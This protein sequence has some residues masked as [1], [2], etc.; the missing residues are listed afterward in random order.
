MHVLSTE[1]NTELLAHVSYLQTITQDCLLCIGTN[2]SP[3]NPTDLSAEVPGEPQTNPG[4]DAG[5][6]S[7]AEVIEAPC[8]IISVSNPQS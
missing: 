3:Q 1:E 8:L 4:Q 6:L 2:T 5:I 7:I